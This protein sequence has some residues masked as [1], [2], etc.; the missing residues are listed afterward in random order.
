M[1]LIKSIKLIQ[2]FLSL[3]ISLILFRNWN[4]EFKNEYELYNIFH[5]MI[6]R[7]E[8]L[9]FLI[10]SLLSIL[11][12]CS[13][14]KTWGVPFLERI[15]YILKN[16]L[17]LSFLG[18]TLVLAALSYSLF[19]LYPLS[20]DEYVMR[21]QA[22]LFSNW[23][24]F[25]QI[26]LELKDYGLRI[27][28]LF[29][30]YDQET[31][32]FTSSYLP[33]YSLLLS[34]FVKCKIVLFLNPILA[35][36][37]LY[38][39]LNL[40]KQLL[41]DFRYKYL[42]GISVFMTP[43]FIVNSMSYY[44][45]PAHLFFNLLWL[46]LRY[47]HKYDRL[48]PWVGIFAISLHQ[49]HFHFLFVLPF[50]IDRWRSGCSKRYY[51]ATV[52][53]LGVLLVVCWKRLFTLPALIPSST[54]IFSLPGH[55]QFLNVLFYILLLVTWTSPLY[56]APFI[57]CVTDYKKISRPMLNL[58][59]GV[60]LSCLFYLFVNFN[61]GHGWGPR[62]LYPVYGNLCLL[63][64]YGLH[65]IQEIKC[66]I[67]SLILVSFIWLAFVLPLRFIQINETVMPFWNSNNYINSIYSKALIIPISKIWY[68]QDLI[69][70]EFS[71]GSSPL[72]V[73]EDVLPIK[74]NNLIIEELNEDKI[75]ELKLKNYFNLTHSP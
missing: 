2:V 43:F 19:R 31:G 15:I 30:F 48:S 3:I 54:T 34:L 60:L 24:I 73:R 47:H 45:F 26:P 28:P 56:I 21:V 75:K 67:T 27:I 8:Y 53:V 63:V 68:G 11:I 17:Y 71:G 52:Y 33:G 64:L 37:S 29:T 23:K 69:R 20:M 12:F 59:M 46:F 13:F 49:P 6:F 44:A 25:G 42:L 51:E 62:Y 22:G 58:L 14:R 55:D 32:S 57:H 10:Y 70:N 40:S 35:A 9:P 1:K 5:F 38:L 50:L 72:R 7:Y 74:I 61:Q 4:S 16:H 41:P 39:F 65:Q 36:A 66:Y 18:F